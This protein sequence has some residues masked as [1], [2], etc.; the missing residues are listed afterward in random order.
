MRECT[1]VHCVSSVPLL[2]MFFRIIP[3]FLSQ[4]LGASFWDAIVETLEES[5]DRLLDLPP[6]PGQVVSNQELFD[7]VLEDA[8]SAM[9]LDPPFT[10]SDD[11]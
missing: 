11:E 2:K 7:N 8:Q 10:S 1:S 5:K 6:S 9:E 4:S 3:S